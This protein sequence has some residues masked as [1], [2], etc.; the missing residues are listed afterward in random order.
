MNKRTVQTMFIVS[1]SIMCWLKRTDTNL[2]NKN[3]LIYFFIISADG[4]FQFSIGV[5]ST[6]EPSQGFDSSDFTVCSYVSSGDLAPGETRTYECNSPSVGR[7]VAVYP[8]YSWGTIDFC[9]LQVHGHPAGER[10]ITKQRIFPKWCSGFVWLWM[11]LK[12]ILTS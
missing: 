7:Y 3:Q 12:G 5:G 9:N 10:L 11:S 1:V 8:V 4:Y 2:S 6:F